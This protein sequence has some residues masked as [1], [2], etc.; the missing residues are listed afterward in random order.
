MLLVKIKPFLKGA[1]GDGYPALT[2]FRENFLEENLTSLF[3]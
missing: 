3:I 1:S 2:G